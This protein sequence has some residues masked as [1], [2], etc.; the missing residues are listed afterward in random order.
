MSRKLKE[1]L[2]KM[3]AGKREYLLR[4]IRAYRAGQRGDWD[5]CKKF[6][7]LGCHPG[8]YAAL[9]RLSKRDKE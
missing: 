2:A 5:T 9:V 6:A 7:E 3:P 4:Q 1:A 8:I